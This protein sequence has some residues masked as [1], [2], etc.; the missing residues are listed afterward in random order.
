MENLL[1]NVNCKIGDSLWR[2]ND[3][4]NIVSVVGLKPYSKTKRERKKNNKKHTQFSCLM[5]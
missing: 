5:I 3:R 4:Q 1:I 2:Q